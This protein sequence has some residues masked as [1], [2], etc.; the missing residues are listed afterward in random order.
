MSKTQ[1]RNMRRK[2]KGNMTPQK[3]KN[4]TIEDLVD[5]EGNESLVVESRI[6][7]RTLNEGA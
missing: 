2:W 4:H 1:S 5:S 3:A 7:I 6:M